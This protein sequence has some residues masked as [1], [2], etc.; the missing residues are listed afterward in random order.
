GPE[1]ERPDLQFQVSHTSY[2]ARLWFPGWRKGAGHQLTA[3]CLLLDPQSRGQVTLGSP[4][5]AELPKVLLN[6]LAEEGDRERL[7]VSIRL[8]REFFAT[9]PA[10]ETVSAEV[11]PGPQAQGDAE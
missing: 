2:M 1:Q 7:R 3:G 6:F 8:M 5:P 10:S 9:P 11:A 4:D